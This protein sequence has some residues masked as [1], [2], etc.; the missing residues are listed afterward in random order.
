MSIKK[1]EKPNLT[2]YSPDLNTD[3]GLPFVT[4]EVKAGFPSPALDFMEYK[5][6]LN[7]VVAEKNPLGNFLYKSGR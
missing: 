1:N 2:F 7:K 3:T 4:H 5:I 6:D